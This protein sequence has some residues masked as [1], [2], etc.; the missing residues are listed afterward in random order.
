M[1]QG[2]ALAEM[3]FLMEPQRQAVSVMLQPATTIA[4]AKQVIAHDGICASRSAIDCACATTA[5]T[6]MAVCE[7]FILADQLIEAEGNGKS[8]MTGKLEKV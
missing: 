1:T 8:S 4:D 2:V 3:T 6:L 7:T 5:M